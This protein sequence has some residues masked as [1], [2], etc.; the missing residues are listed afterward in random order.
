M[1]LHI[2]NPHQQPHTNKRFIT[3]HKIT[4]TYSQF[5][6]DNTGHYLL[7]NTTKFEN[8]QLESKLSSLIHTYTYNT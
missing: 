3:S 4:S 5:C 6:P 1:G 8:K 7:G 2:Q